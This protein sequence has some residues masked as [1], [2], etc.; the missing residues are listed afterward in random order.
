MENNNELRELATSVNEGLLERFNEVFGRT[1]QE[2]DSIEV[3]DA[4]FNNFAMVKD[5]VVF[6]FVSSE[7]VVYPVGDFG[8][9]GTCKWDETKNQFVD[10][11]G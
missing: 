8:F 11:A 3:V 10:Y 5:G 6:A 4:P 2:G 7:G 9:E 1:P